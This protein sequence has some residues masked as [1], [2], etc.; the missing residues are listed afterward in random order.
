MVERTEDAISELAYSKEQEEEKGD[1]FDEIVDCL[2]H[3]HFVNG[4]E[5]LWTGHRV[6]YKIANIPVAQ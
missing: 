6:G 4:W 2:N 5:V 3:T 1:L